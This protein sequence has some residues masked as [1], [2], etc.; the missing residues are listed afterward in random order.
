MLLL[1]TA[2]L[3]LAMP[4]ASAQPPPKPRTDDATKRTLI[5][6]VVAVVNN[7]I[8]LESDLQ[9]RL[10][11]LTGEDGQAGEGRRS[12]AMRARALDDMVN[13]ELILQAADKAKI[14]VD[15]SEID[16]HIQGIKEQ[17]QLDDAGLEEE[18]RKQGQTMASFRND[19]RKQLLRY[20]AINQQIR[21]K[22]NITDADVQAAYDQMTRRADSVSAV[23]V[24]HILIATPPN[25]TPADLEAAKAKA[26]AI[27]RRLDAGED[28]AK[29]AA[30]V[31]DDAASKETGGELGWFERGTL[32]WDSVVFDLAV[33][34]TSDPVAGPQGFHLLRVK[35]KKS[36]KV[37]SFDQVK[38][39][40]K[41]DMW[42][43]ETEKK[44]SEWIEQ[45][46]RDAYIDLKL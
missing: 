16:A 10:L 20:R 31:S 45:L 15:P 34:G 33:G 46:R 13:E 26:V 43:R 25:P 22:I 41:D 7:S 5:D 39:K 17:Y 24:A 36:S 21:P 38:A 8:I 12:E 11:L 19:T 30:E 23:F 28:F 42:R 29:V 37:G 18:L 6:R 4:L 1:G 27:K 14:D 9:I 40:I 32:A 2:L 35:D 44:T 3:P